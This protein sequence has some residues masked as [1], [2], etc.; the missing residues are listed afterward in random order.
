MYK[1]VF[2]TFSNGVLSKEYFGE[3]VLTVDEK[4]KDFR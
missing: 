1:A 4:F 2:V 3:N